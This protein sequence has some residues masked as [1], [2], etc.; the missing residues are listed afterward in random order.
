MI[1]RKRKLPMYCHWAKDRHGKYRIRFRS[2]S[3][4]H[5]IYSAPGTPGF[6]ADY[7]QCLLNRRPAIGASEVKPGSIAKLFAKY[8]ETREFKE[9]AESTRKVFR[10]D[11]ERFKAKYGDKRVAHLKRRHLNDI[12]DAMSDRPQAAN[13]LLKRLRVVLDLALDLEWITVNPARGLK[14]YSKKTEGFYTWTNEDMDAFEERHPSGS[15]AR[16]A[17][18]L[19]YY[20]ASRRGDVVKL[21]RQHAKN[22]RLKFTQNKTHADMDLPI[23]PELA[24]EIEALEHNELTFLITEYGKPF[25]P[26]GFGNWFKERC[27]EAGLPK[28]TAHGLRK[29]ATRTV[30]ES[31]KTTAQAGGLT[32]HQTLAEIDH[33]SEKRDQA[34]LADV[35]VEA[36]GRTKNGTK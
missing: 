14:G 35:A 15:K 5:Y 26:E 23:H 11:L 6:A 3:F 1:L 36:L 20:T 27:K 33:Y 22:G 32:G 25:T 8:Y 24:R 34:A 16:L 4:S 13:N 10:G 29:A 28:C 19:L 31:G 7:E 18:A 21:G 9:L 2:R 12:V 30:I 17:Y